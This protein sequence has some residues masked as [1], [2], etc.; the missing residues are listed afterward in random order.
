LFKFVPSTVAPLTTATTSSPQSKAYSAAEA[1]LRHR[2]NLKM[3]V[4]IMLPL[5]FAAAVELSETAICLDTR[6]RNPSGSW[7]ADGQPFG[8]GARHRQ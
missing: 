1:P 2:T 4:D 3:S 5:P 6:I 7:A 8:D